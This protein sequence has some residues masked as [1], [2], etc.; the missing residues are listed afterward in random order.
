MRH[1]EFSLTKN[2]IYLNHAAVAPWPKRTA[3][4]VKAS[5]VFTT[6]PPVPAGNDAFEPWLIDKYFQ[7]TYGA[8]PMRRAVQKEI[9]DRLSELILEGRFRVFLPRAVVEEWA[10]AGIPGLAE[11]PTPRSTGASSGG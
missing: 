1:A 5:G 6:H 7:P 4:A 8:R 10:R 11:P 9:E 2:L 3:E